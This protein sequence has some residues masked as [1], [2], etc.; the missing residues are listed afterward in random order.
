MATKSGI[1]ISANDGPTQVILTVPDKGRVTAVT[2]GGK[3]KG[4]L[5][6][7]CGSKIWKRKIQQYA[8]AVWSSW[9]KVVPTKL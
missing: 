5:Y 4:T 1:Q 3:D 9:T 8:L 6:A 2:L 7:F